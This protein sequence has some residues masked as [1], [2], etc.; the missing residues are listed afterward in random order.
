MDKGKKVV[1]HRP[2][3]ASTGKRK[4]MEVDHETMSWENLTGNE[5]KQWWQ[6]TADDHSLK[7]A[8]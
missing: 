7:I 4:K 3:I 1:Q 8:L 5:C 2:K 6:S